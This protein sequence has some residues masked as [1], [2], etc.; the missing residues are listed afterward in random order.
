MALPVRRPSAPTSSTRG[1]DP[2]QDFADLHEQFGQLV[3]SV[4]GPTPG[5]GSL[6]NDPSAPNGAFPWRPLADV[7]ETEDAYVVEV[8]VP[9]V[10]RD[11]ITLE[12]TGSELTI[13]GEYKEKEKAG[14]LRHR[15]RRVGQF[16]YRTLLPREVNPEAI[17]A[18]LAEG[19]LT[20]T[21]PKSETVKPRRI[22]ITAH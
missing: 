12:V 10:Q 13:R 20:V 16:E 18:D 4:F 11:D 15:T 8:D 3:Q 9:G 17:T 2:V 7:S 5:F 21:V 6:L 19:V 22:E 1:W 14:L